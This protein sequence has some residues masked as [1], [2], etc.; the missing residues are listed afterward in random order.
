MGAFGTWLEGEETTAGETGSAIVNTTAETWEQECVRRVEAE[1]SGSG[2]A[3][4]DE[5]IAD[6]AA[7][8]DAAI[9]DAQTQSERGVYSMLAT[10]PPSS[11]MPV[12][13]G[14]AGAPATGS[15]TPWIFGGVL[16]AALGAGAYFFLR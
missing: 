16:V 5:M 15:W 9:A 11:I 12:G 3:A 7:R 13:K 2:S 6:E 10:M 1:S 8:T 4:I 14:A